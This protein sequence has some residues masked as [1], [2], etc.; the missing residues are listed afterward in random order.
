[1]K[2][3]ALIYWLIYIPALTLWVAQWRGEIMFPGQLGNEP[4]KAGTGG[5]GEGGKGFSANCCPV[6]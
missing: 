2:K 1:M 3:K 6:T 4:G 5:R